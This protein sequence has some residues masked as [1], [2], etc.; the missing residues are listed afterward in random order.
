MSEIAALF[1]MSLPADLTLVERDPGQVIAA[2]WFS[3]ANDA[4]LPYKRLSAT[5]HAKIAIRAR[6]SG[7]ETN[8]ESTILDCPNY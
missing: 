4:P 3:W 2:A 8:D 7:F 6:A 1:W 5:K